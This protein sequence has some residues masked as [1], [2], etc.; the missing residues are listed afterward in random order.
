MIA[1]FL[2]TLSLSWIPLFTFNGGLPKEFSR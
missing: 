1:A 2:A